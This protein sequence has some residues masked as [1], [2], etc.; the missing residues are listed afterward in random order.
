[1]L[2]P[3]TF[4]AINQARNGRSVI[5][6]VQLFLVG[7]LHAVTSYA[8]P[9]HISLIQVEAEPAKPAS[10]PGKWVFLGTAIALVLFGGA[11]AGLTIALMG[12]DEV[13]LQVISTSGEGKEKKNATK[14]LKLLHRGKHWVLV[15]LLV[16]N[17]IT[18]ETL[19]IV[20][21]RSIGGGYA[22]A[23]SSTVLVS[24]SESNL[25]T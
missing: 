12:Q 22:A 18:N 13:Y 16:G 3:T 5:S 8:L 21:D 6:I 15:T 4:L 10:D 14:V 11:F 20:L 1:M 23:I 2:S 7:L 9:Y 17:V 25:L 24:T 19:P